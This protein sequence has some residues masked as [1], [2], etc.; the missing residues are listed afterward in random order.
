M[1][2]FMMKDY[3]NLNYYSQGFQPKPINMMQ[4]PINYPNNNMNVVPG[5]TMNPTNV[6]MPMYYPMNIGVNN[7]SV[8]VLKYPKKNVGSK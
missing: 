6:F 8:G 4:M 1:P 5:M 2:P 3:M 7:N